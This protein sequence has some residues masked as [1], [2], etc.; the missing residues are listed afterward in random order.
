MS[1]GWFDCTIPLIV[2]VNHSLCIGLG[3]CS[4]LVCHTQLG[5]LKSMGPWVYDSVLVAEGV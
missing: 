2:L 3:L 5:D 4:D 1:S